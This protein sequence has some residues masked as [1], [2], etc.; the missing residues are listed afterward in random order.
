LVLRSKRLQ[1]RLTA[2][3][4]ANQ[5]ILEKRKE[6]LQ[7]NNETKTKLFSIIGHDLR[8]PIGAL[9]GL[10]KLFKDGE[11]SREEFLSFIPKLRADVDHI[12]F[13]L[14]NLLSWGHTQLNGSVTKPSV[15][16]FDHIV[17]ENINL[18]TEIAEQK[19]IRIVNKIEANIH[20]WSDPNQI[21]IVV[22]NLI[23]NALKFTPEN[24]M[25]TVE[26]VEREENWEIAIRDTGVGMDRI[27][28]GKL[29]QEKT[30]HSTYGTNNEKGTGLGLSL[31]KEMVE[32]NNGKIWADSMLRKGSSFYF[33][34]PK[35]RQE[36]G[37]AV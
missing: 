11:V 31:C 23:S 21:D 5:E 7:A 13:T 27:T 33:T 37:K 25:V 16:T 10:L 18:L 20:V 30:N 19:S 35:A 14:N 4:Q 1:K 24:G 36:L 12:Y 29:F 6:E 3:L 26:A 28:L 2:E 9:Q 8:G 15:V 17:E 34:L 32:K 22:R